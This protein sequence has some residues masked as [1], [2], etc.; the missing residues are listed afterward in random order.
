MNLAGRMSI[1][2]LSK[3]A[4]VKV[5]TIRYYEQIKLMPPPPRTEGNYRA[6]KQEHLHRLQFIHRCRSFGFTLDQVRDLLRLSTQPRQ[7]C[8]EVDRITANHLK[9]IERKVA[10]LRGLAAELR[11]IQRRCPGKSLIGN[12]RILEAL[13]PAPNRSGSTRGRSARR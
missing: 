10:D 2:H 11:R 4:G 13:S 3:E 7:K 12:C 9:E 6:Y 8:S 1:G 5:V